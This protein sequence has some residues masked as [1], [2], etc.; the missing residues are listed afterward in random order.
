MCRGCPR[1]R[2]GPEK[3]CTWLQSARRDAGHQLALPPAAWADAARAGARHGCGAACLGRVQQA[4]LSRTRAGG[5][6]RA[7]GQ[8][9]GYVHS[10]TGGSPRVAVRVACQRS[11]YAGGAGACTVSRHLGRPSLSESHQRPHSTRRVDM[12]CSSTRAWMHVG[13]LG[14]MFDQ[15]YARVPRHCTSS[16]LAH[17]PRHG[18]LVYLAIAGSQP[19]IA[20]VRQALHGGLPQDERSAALAS[21]AAG[22]TKV[23]PPPDQGGG[24]AR[25]GSL[26]LG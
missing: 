24:L 21:L 25:L 14:C 20:M 13:P 6:T 4:S 1:W 17:V 3:P 16:W 9:S 10:P 7:A 11:R 5:R 23:P 2:C 18:W 19:Y 8:G 26:W 15:S 22:R 12:G